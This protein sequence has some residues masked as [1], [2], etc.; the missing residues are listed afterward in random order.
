MAL[1]VDFWNQLPLKTNAELFDMLARQADYLP[2]ALAAAREE[3]SKRNLPPEQ[4]SQHETAAQAR[5]AADDAKA[6]EPLGWPMRILLFV[7]CAV[8]IG[9]FAAVY[10]QSKGNH[11]KSWECL[12]TICASVLFYMALVALTQSW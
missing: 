10:Y 6:T 11:K 4:V 9:L 8:K 5:K 7:F 1:S 12:L 3:L 2:Q